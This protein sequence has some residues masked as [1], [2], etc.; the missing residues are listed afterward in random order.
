MSKISTGNKIGQAAAL[1]GKLRFVLRRAVYI[2][3]PSHLPIPVRQKKELARGLPVHRDRSASAIRYAKSPARVSLGNV[4]KRNES[5]QQQ[6]D[7]ERAPLT[8]RAL[9]ARVAEIHKYARG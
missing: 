9:F 2:S 4:S 6:R 7:S 3:H 8:R 5:E 1:A